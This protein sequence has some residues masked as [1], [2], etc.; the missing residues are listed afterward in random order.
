MAMR[1]ERWAWTMRTASVRIQ[2]AS[3]GSVDNSRRMYFAALLLRSARKP[4]WVA[5]YHKHTTPWQDHK[6]TRSP[7]CPNACENAVTEP[8]VHQQ[9]LASIHHARKET[10]IL[11]SKGIARCRTTET[12]LVGREY[13]STT[14]KALSNKG[15]IFQEFYQGRRVESLT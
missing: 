9:S 4:A 14:T 7:M 2:R 1:F 13:F 15:S 11:I 3:H 8:R 5:A 12:A 10:N 6:E